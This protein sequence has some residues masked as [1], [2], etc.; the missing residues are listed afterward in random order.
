M[1]Q[2]GDRSELQRKLPMQRSADSLGLVCLFGQRGSPRIGDV[3]DAGMHDLNAS[4]TEISPPIITYGSD[5]R[6][7]P[8][9]QVVKPNTWPFP[10]SPIQISLPVLNYFVSSLDIRCMPIN[11]LE[12]LRYTI[13]N[14]V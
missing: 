13:G 4:S 11:N 6:K 10:Q 1:I 3:R 14:S 5:I 12:H 8:T 2:R 9:I 7:S